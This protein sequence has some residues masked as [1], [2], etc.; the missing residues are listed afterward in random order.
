MSVCRFEFR[1]SQ[2]TV[3]KGLEPKDQTNGLAVAVTLLGDEVKLGYRL[4]G[5][6][7]SEVHS[8]SLWLVPIEN[9]EK[10]LSTSL[11]VQNCSYLN[12][13]YQNRKWLNQLGQLV[14]LEYLLKRGYPNANI[15]FL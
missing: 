7:A 15:F 11:W 10:K 2:I 3:I 12:F 6:S 9:T 4:P 5:E 8:C 1:Y 13:K 14:R